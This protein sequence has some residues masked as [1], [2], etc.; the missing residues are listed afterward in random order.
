MGYFLFILGLITVPI[1]IILIIVNIIR[2]KAIKKYVIAILI[3]LVLFITGLNMV[4]TEELDKEK[5]LSASNELEKKEVEEK[6]DFILS[7]ADKEILSKDYKDLSDDQI[8]RLEE[9]NKNIEEFDFKDQEIIKENKE[10]LDEQ[11]IIF[12]KEELEKEAKVKK[13]QELKEA[14][15]KARKEKEIQEQKEQEIK[16]EEAK[17]KEEKEKYNS[18][19]SRDDLARD[20]QGLLGEYVRFNGKVVQVMENKGYNQYRFAVDDDYDKMILIEIDENL[21]D[22]NILEDDYITIEGISSG[23]ITYTTVMGAEQTI[24]SVIVDKFYLK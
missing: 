5:N 14:E 20:K 8:L 11:K 6:N 19:I 18:G 22:S 13:E 3:G 4:P 23:N 7:E 17:A 9:I 10:R 16:E 24:P 21:L 15:E 12:D 2:K 1:S